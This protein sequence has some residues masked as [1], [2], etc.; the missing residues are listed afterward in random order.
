MTERRAPGPASIAL[1]VAGLMT[2][3]GCGPS[4][5]L[6]S[7][8]Q[9]QQ[10]QQQQPQRIAS[11]TLATDEILDE[12][13]PHER[14]VAV[15]HL[16]DD[17]EVSNVAGRYATSIARVRDANPE[18]IIALQP[19]LVCVALYNTADSLELLVRSGL[20]IYRNESMS[21]FDEIEAGLERLGRRVGEPARSRAMVERMQTRRRRLADRLRGVPARPR[22]LFW[23][24][25]FTSGRGS[26]ID[27]II[28]EA[29]GVNV[30]AELGLA[31]SVEIAPERVVAADP[32]VMLISRWKADDRQSE[33]A[34]HPILRRLRAVRE[35]HVVAIE[36][37]YLT[38]ISQYAVEGAERL[39]RALHPDRFAGGVG[40]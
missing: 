14:V 19:D 1:L 6:K 11:L 17:V 33:V 3:P 18:Q 22:V 37:R 36:S 10:Q 8:A 25:G 16:A 7:P 21:S 31:D 38:T 27:D 20:P 30:A 39:A 24:A 15:T 35:G 32:E 5:R 40:P 23:S 26:T 12:L 34:N 29:G 9:Q 4:P 13:V 28:R 2:G